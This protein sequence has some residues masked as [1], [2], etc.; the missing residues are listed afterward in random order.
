MLPF[1]SDFEPPWWCM[2]PHLQTIWPQLFRTAPDPGY[3][4]ERLELD[5]GDFLDID[6]LEPDLDSP[7]VLIA[8][9]LGGNSRSH[10]V[11][12]LVD[13]LSAAGLRSAVVHHRGC[14]GQPNRL[15]RSYHGGHSED[16]DAAI[17]RLRKQ[18]PGTPLFAAGYSLG[19]SMLIHWLSRNHHILT[20]ACVVSVPWGLAESADR[21]ERGLARIYQ[22]H[23]VSRMKRQ[24][25]RKAESVVLP[26]D[27]PALGRVKTFR[28]FDN[29]I[30]APCH[31]FRDA[32][33]YY[34]LC[35]PRRLLREI[36]TNTLIIHAADDPMMTVQV[37][38]EEDELPLGGNLKFEL[39]RRG[40]HCGFVRGSWPHQARYWAERR[41]TN[42]FRSNLDPYGARI[43]T[44]SW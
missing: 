42:Y 21:M 29:M 43:D 39:S 9:G 5:D 44:S 14:S 33:E 12:G 7:I 30:T 20:A 4:R 3:R 2:N 23:L 28:Q 35:S 34:A 18:E 31:G 27:I 1:N 6:W 10:Y 22:G 40:G 38:P 8:H 13:E 17:R 11:R 41:V 19:G 15:P 37:I 16:L 26:V 24:L 32:Q 25:L 36:R